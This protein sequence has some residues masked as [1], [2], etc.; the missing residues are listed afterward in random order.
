MALSYSST[1]DHLPIAGIEDGV[2]LMSDGSVR[3]ILKVEP[4]NFEL[5]SEQEQ[6][7]IIYSYQSFLNS[8][9]FPIQIV[10]RSKRLDLESYL[11]KLQLQEESITNDLLRLQ[12][13]DYITYLRLLI[14]KANIMSK[15]FYIS[16][17]YVSLGGGAAKAQASSLFHKK[18]TGPILDQKEFERSKTEVINRAE[19][20]G[21]GLAHIGSRA[22]LLDTQRLIELFYGIYNPDIAG[23]ERLSN[24]NIAD[25]NSGVI[26]SPEAESLGVRV[27]AQQQAQTTLAPA[28]P[29]PP[30]A[31]VPV[32]PQAP[33]PPTP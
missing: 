8:L 31:P 24:V 19:I 33:Q 12:L 11:Q 13:N 15:H 1:Q 17:S 9:E 27:E 30:A 6:D 20:I 25:L 28:I 10:I 32:P 7:A 23:E 14:S 4:T 18:P 29:T 16:V 3:A 21:T 26:T 22:Q 5:K 2:V